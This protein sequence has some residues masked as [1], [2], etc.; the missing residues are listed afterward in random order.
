[1]FVEESS[2]LEEN[3]SQFLYVSSVV[4]LQ[5]PPAPWSTRARRNDT[6]SLQALGP[7]KRT[8]RRRTPLTLRSTARIFADT[9]G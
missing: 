7:I 4:H 6:L 2:P 1:M 9:V 8:L 3:Q 5:R